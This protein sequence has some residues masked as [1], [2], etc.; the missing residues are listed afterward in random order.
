MCDK[1][2]KAIGRRKFLQRT[3]A[4]TAA[5][6]LPRAGRVIGAQPAA[7]LQPRL[8]RFPEKCDLVL[9]TDRPPQL[10]TPIRYFLKDLTPNEAF[11]VRWHMAGIPTEIDTQSFRSNGRT[12]D[13]H[14]CVDRADFVEVNALD[15]SCMNLGFRGA[16]R[17]K[18]RNRRL[19]DGGTDRGVGRR[20]FQVHPGD[21]I[22]IGRGLVATRQDCRREHS[23]AR[24]G[25]PHFFFSS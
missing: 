10:E 7:S 2:N 16:E 12:D 18:N 5:A 15:R 24:E 21:V 8:V 19:L 22:W 1:A 6:Y 23:R 17:F 20:G 11:F 3:A 9:L 14:N 25:M 13:V 4:L